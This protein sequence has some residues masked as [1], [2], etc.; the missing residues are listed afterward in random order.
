MIRR[1]HSAFIDTYKL[2]L[3]WLPFGWGRSSLP[4]QLGTET[5]HHPLA[6]H[7]ECASWIRHSYGHQS[8]YSEDSREFFPRTLWKKEM[9]KWNVNNWIERHSGDSMFQLIPKANPSLTHWTLPARFVISHR[10]SASDPSSTWRFVGWVRK[11]CLLAVTGRDAAF[12]DIVDD[13]REKM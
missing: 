12:V 4:V 11:Y 10:K 13:G 7:F 6:M 3:N 2:Q 9:E 8:C 1:F 5:L